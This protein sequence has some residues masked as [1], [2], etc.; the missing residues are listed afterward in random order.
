MAASITIG[1]W[2]GFKGLSERVKILAEY[3]HIPYEMKLYALGTDEWAKDKEIL[4]T[5][6]PNLPYLK[7]GETI[8]TE[9]RAILHYLILKAGR[10]ELLG[11]NRLQSVEVAQVSDVIRDLQTETESAFRKQDPSMIEDCKKQLL[12]RFE[13][14]SRHLGSKKFICGDDFTV[15]DIHLHAICQLHLAFKATVLD[16]LPNLKEHFARVQA[17][18]EV[19]AY[20]ASDRAPEPVI[21]IPFLES[22]RKILNP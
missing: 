10:Q 4:K 18:P 15:A 12:P 14:L 17:L 16:H 5:D 22:T 8:V 9:S 19:A 11:K 1:Y 2:S 21:P 7:D 20:L 6:F 3:L 13:K